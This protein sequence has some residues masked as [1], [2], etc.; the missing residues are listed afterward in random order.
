MSLWT[1]KGNEPAKAFYERLDWR[2][3]GA[4]RFDPSARAPA[5]RMLRPLS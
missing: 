5:L 4:T 2:A 3:D 1:L